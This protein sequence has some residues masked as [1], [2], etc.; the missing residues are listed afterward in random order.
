[1]NPENKKLAEVVISFFKENKNVLLIPAVD[2]SHII[3]DQNEM[4]FIKYSLEKDY[5]FIERS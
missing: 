3:S 2:L 4:A 1:M 5:G